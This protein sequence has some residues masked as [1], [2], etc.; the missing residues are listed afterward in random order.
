MTATLVKNKTVP[1]SSPK[2]VRV[3]GFRKLAHVGSKNESHGEIL[4]PAAS[5]EHVKMANESEFRF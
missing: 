1:F 2:L 4:L 5:C 3:R